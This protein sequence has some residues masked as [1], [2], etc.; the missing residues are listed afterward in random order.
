MAEPLLQGGAIFSITNNVCM[1]KIL[2]SVLFLSKSF[3]VTR[4]YLLFTQVELI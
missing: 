3:N 4:N 2:V 1:K